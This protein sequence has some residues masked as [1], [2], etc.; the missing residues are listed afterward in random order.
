[1]DVV[2]QTQ[3]VQGSAN[4]VGMLCSL[5]IGSQ[6][7]E[8]ATHSPF[9]AGADHR[10][11]ANHVGRRNENENDAEDRASPTPEP[12]AAGGTRSIDLFV[13]TWIDFRW[14]EALPP[15]GMSHVERFCCTILPTVRKRATS[16]D[17]EP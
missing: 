12:A 3:K 9:S 11:R 4:A 16:E 13:G 14:L 17:A 6:R 5:D 7:G 1:M 2:R 15:I 8:Y 10:H